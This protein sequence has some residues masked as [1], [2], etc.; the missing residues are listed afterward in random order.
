MRS[1]CSRRARAGRAVRFA[2]AIEGIDLGNVTAVEEAR[3][4]A[5]MKLVTE[6]RD[7]LDQMNIT[8][9]DGSIDFDLL[10]SLSSS[11]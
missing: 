10:S 9:P 11:E 7:L 8:R 2:A 1:R 6:Q 5:V 4:A 3:D